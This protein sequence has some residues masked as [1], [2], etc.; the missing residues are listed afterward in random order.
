VKFI[1]RV[2]EW[3]RRFIRGPH[4]FERTIRLLAARGIWNQKREGQYPYRV[5][6]FE[7][8]K[9][10][11]KRVAFYISLHPAALPQFYN[12]IKAAEYPFTLRFKPPEVSDAA[13]CWR[14]IRKINE[15]VEW[16]LARQ[17]RLKASLKEEKYMGRQHLVIER[18]VPGSNEQKET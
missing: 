4:S 6:W 14:I 5:L 11:I 8:P 7:V 9:C 1:R 18:F 3:C 10:S 2:W 17:V 13:S 12:L 15:A 16:M